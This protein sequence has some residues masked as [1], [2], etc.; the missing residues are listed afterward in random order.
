MVEK[1]EIRPYVSADMDKIQF[2]REALI[3]SLG[4]PKQEV[5]ELYSS[6]GPAYTALADGAAIAIGGVNIL[7]PG[8]GE[9][10][11]IFGRGYEEHGIFLHRNAVKTLARIARENKLVRIQA[12]ARADQTKDVPWLFSLGFALE[13]NMPYYWQGKTFARFAK[14]YKENI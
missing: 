1:Y 11:I 6:R 3:R 8:T 5:A 2:D 7:W 14:I 13:G 10:W 4:K 9:A 12:V